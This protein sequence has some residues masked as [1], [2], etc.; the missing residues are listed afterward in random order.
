M[1]PCLLPALLQRDGCTPPGENRPVGTSEEVAGVQFNLTKYTK[2]P[3]S[4]RCTGPGMTASAPS[5]R[6]RGLTGATQLGPGLAAP[7]GQQSPGSEPSG[8]GGPRGSTTWLGLWDQPGDPQCSRKWGVACKGRRWSRWRPQGRDGGWGSQ[9][10]GRA[11]PG[12]SSTFRTGTGRDGHRC[13][14]GLLPANSN[15]I[16]STAPSPLCTDP[17]PQKHSQETPRSPSTGYQFRMLTGFLSHK[18][19]GSFFPHFGGD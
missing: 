12:L 7:G 5:L 10:G 13:G 17:P 9:P 15:F 4:L 3:E 11:E 6:G 1:Q 19:L 18:A 14:L 2:F 8:T 16:H